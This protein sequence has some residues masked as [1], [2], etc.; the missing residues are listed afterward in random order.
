MKPTILE[1][2]KKLAEYMGTKEIAMY[3][4]DDNTWDGG[5]SLEYI[6]QKC[7]NYKRQGLNVELR[8]RVIV[9]ED[10]AESLDAQ[11]PIMDKLVKLKI[12]FSI[13]YRDKHVLIKVFKQRKYIFE[14][15]DAERDYPLLQAYALYYAI[16][17]SEEK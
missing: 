14:F 16:E 2:N 17:R 13:T 4:I 12:S 5:H 6:T 10:Y 11:I 8:E 15:E 9:I 7:N 3:Y 1:V